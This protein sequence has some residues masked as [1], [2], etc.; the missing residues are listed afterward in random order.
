MNKYQSNDRRE[1]SFQDWENGFIWG[2]LI[3]S[4]S[5]SATLILIAIIRVLF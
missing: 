1:Q 5:I 3:A 4:L 2:A